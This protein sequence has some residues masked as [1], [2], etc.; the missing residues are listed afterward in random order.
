MVAAVLAL[1]ALV[2]TAGAALAIGGAIVGTVGYVV[3]RISGGRVLG[4]A[5]RE[6]ERLGIEGEEV[7]APSDFAARN[8][9]R[10][11][12]ASGERTG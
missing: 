9:Q 8:P 5:R 1:L 4:P 6:W 10:L 11:A 2:V 12:D 7:F 3:R